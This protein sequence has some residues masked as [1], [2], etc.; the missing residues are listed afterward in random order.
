[1]IGWNLNTD[2]FTLGQWLYGRIYEYRCDLSPDGRYLLYFAARYGRKNSVEARVEELINAQ[3]A[4]FDWSTFTES[5][6]LK[7]SRLREELD[8]R[9]RREHASELE[10]LRASRDY[11]DASWTAISRA[12]YLKALDLWF[13]GSGWNGGGWFVDANHVWLNRPRPDRGDHF[14]HT[15]SGMFKEVTEA[16]D[17]QLERE[18]NGE[19]P[20]IYLARLE[21]DGWRECGEGQVHIEYVKQLPGDLHLIKRFYFSWSG[22]GKNFPGYGCYWETHDLRR[23]TQL[24][25]GGE[26]WRWADY[27][28][29]RKRVLFAANGAIF[30]L[31]LKTPDASPTLLC[32]FNGMTYNRLSAP[33]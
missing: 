13:N 15:V 26:E 25:S 2:E 5:G 24:L 11:T 30:A 32:D 10:K 27:D 17:M 1:M 21:R 12:P 3:L 28:A 19:C 23:G 14:H 6:Y 33:Y 9:I 22:K 20:G 29:K 8:G 4:E 7:Y 16:P 31:S 18:N